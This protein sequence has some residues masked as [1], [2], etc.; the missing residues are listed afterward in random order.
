[1]DT[2]I[3]RRFSDAIAANMAKLRLV[4]HGINAS[5]LEST[6]LYGTCTEDACLM[7]PEDDAIQAFEIL[8]SSEEAIVCTEGADA[9]IGHAAAEDEVSGPSVIRSVLQCRGSEREDFYVVPLGVH[10][11][12]LGVFADAQKMRRSPF[13]SDFTWPS[14]LPT[15]GSVPDERSQALTP[16]RLLTGVG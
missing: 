16:G 13:H 2:I 5:V 14:A 4:Q 15:A 7:V 8:E 11:F 6:R 1:M 12:V 3:V 9:E 10:R